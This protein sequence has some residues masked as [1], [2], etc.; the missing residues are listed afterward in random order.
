LQEVECLGA[1]VAAPV[2]Q[3][4]KKY[5]EALTPEKLDEIIDQL[6]R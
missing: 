3:I 5:Y 2:C 4:G 1:C 6:K